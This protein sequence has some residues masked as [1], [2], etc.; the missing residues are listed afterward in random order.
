MGGEEIVRTDEPRAI[1]DEAVRLARQEDDRQAGIA[2][3][4]P[5]NGRHLDSV[6][7]IHVDVEN[8]KLG[9]VGDEGIQN[10]HRPR[11]AVDLD[12][13]SRQRTADVF[14]EELVV[15]DDEDNRRMGAAVLDVAIENLD[16]IEP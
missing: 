11:D 15:V 9:L 1:A 4:L 2:W 5:D 6:D 16:Q 13:L 3:N 7:T 8:E 12:P 10:L 14:D